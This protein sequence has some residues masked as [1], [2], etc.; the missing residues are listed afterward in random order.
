MS[1][2][3]SG[4]KVRMYRQGHGDCFLLAF[5]GREGRRKRTVYVLIDCGLKPGS[6]VNDQKIEAVINDIHDATNGHV[7]IVIA[8]HEHQDHVNGFAKKK[9]RKHLFDKITIGQCWLAWTEDGSDELAN[10]LRER[11]RDTLVTLAYAQEKVESRN[12]D[13]DLAARL[14]DLLST[15]TGDDGRPVKPG[16]EGRGILEAFRMEKKANPFLTTSEL[17]A[18]AVRGITNKNAIKYLRNR[19]EESTVYLSPDSPPASIPLVKDLRIYTLGPPRNEALLVDLDPVGD[20]EFHL[21]LSGRNRNLGGD[22]RGF[23]Q[24][25]ATDTAT[26]AEFQP[27]S[28]RHGIPQDDILTRTLPNASAGAQSSQQA[29]LDYLRQVYGGTGP[30]ENDE[31]TDWRRI[32]EEWLGTAEGLALRLNNEVNNTSL[33]LAFQLPKTGKV[34]LFTGDAQRGS[35]IGWSDLEWTD[36]ENRTTTVRDLLARCVLYKVGHHGSHNATLNGTSADDH[37]NLGWM[38]RGEFADDFVAM[39]PANTPWALG[40]SKP[41]MHPLPQIEEALTKKTR[42]RVFRSDR[43]AIEQPDEAVMCTAE[44]QAFK[45]LCKETKLYFEYSV[46]DR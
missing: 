3:T 44:W 4:V 43:D 38:A 27:F 26:N 23:A 31:A 11:F 6:E 22:T 8:T 32:D 21:G 7:D 20:E 5:A 25:V 41:W 42:G 16:E 28:K 36:D 9:N 15:E 24:A 46:E 37:A 33:V 45:K 12:K 29:R 1:S 19:S 14:S 39:I 35:W 13:S 17:A 18:S 30:D 40:K 10:A 2:P 34:L